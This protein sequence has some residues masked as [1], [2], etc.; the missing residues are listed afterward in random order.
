MVEACFSKL[1]WMSISIP[2]NVTESTG[3]T[4]IELFILKS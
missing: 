4:S 2:K 1:N 3:E